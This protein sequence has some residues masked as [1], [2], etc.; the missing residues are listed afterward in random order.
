M[1]NFTGRA[2]VN[3]GS[4]KALFEDPAWDDRFDVL[5]DLT[6][7]TK[8]IRE[9]MGTDCNEHRMKE[10]MNRRMEARGVKVSRPRGLGKSVNSETFLETAAERFEAAYLLSLHF[11]SRGAGEYAEV[12]TN[13]ARAVDKRIEVYAKYRADAPATNGEHRISF[14]TYNL[15]IE[16]VKTG[17]VEVRQ[18][19][20]CNTKHP[21]MRRQHGTA[22][23]PACAT[24]ELRVP[25]VEREMEAR[26]AA[27][28]LS[29][30]KQIKYG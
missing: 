10:E 9:L 7:R 23:C 30:D 27:Y 5:M 4:R 12:E 20:T 24:Q 6:S 22:H 26:M 15:L 13:Y 28:R 19:S 3:S 21:V 8:L 29:R 2:L 25:E 1:D 17:D 16:A 11:G 14:E 18:C